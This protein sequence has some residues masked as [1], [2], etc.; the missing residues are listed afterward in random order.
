MG[1]VESVETKRIKV[2]GVVLC[3]AIMRKW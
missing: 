3:W 1:T 2:G